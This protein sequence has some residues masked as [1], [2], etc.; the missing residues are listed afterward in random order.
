MRA[1][2]AL[3]F[4]ATPAHAGPWPRAQGEAYVFV[5]HEGGRDGWTGFYTEYG[6]P[7]DLTFGLDAGGNLMR[8]ATDP[9]ERR[10][11][12]FLRMPVLTKMERPG[13]LA[14]WLFAVEAG[15][16]HDEPETGEGTVRYSLGT[17]VGRGLQT[18]WGDGWTT[19]DLR[20]AYGSDA[21]LRIETQAVAGLKP[22]PRWTVEMGLFAEQEIDMTTPVMDDPEITFAPTVQYGLGRWGDLRLGIA[23]DRDGDSEARLGWARSF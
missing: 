7:Y 11:R 2:L 23:I 1:L 12:A 19:F 22:T 8:T 6:L 5:G 14:P 16:G 18:R 4:L 17:S 20:V 9:G 3:L 15:I 21:P 10:V 13:W